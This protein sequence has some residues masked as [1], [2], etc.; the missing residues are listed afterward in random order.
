MR[1]KNLAA[2][3]LIVIMGVGVLGC[4]SEKR[5]LSTTASKEP[6]MAMITE[7]SEDQNITTDTEGEVSQK[8]DISGAHVPRLEITST[9]YD[10]GEDYE[11]FYGSYD[12]AAI[13]SEDYPELKQAVDRWFADF[14][15]TYYSSADRY[16]EDAKE[17]MRSEDYDMGSFYL[18][19]FAKVTR[20]D[21]RITSIV[22]DETGFTGGAHGFSYM[23]GVTFDSKTGKEITFADLGNVKEDVKSYVTNYVEQ[24]RQEG[25]SYDFFEDNIDTALD[26]PVW[27][28]NGL[29]LNVIFNEY[30]IASYAEGRTVVTIPYSEL[31]G[32][33]NDYCLDGE[34]MYVE[35]MQNVSCDIDVDE[36]ETKEKIEL[37]G[38]Y[39]ENGEMELSLK[40]DDLSLE[41]G[42]C[43]RI[44]N[45]YYVKAE[46]GRSFVLVSYDAMSDD[47]V[48]ELIEVSSGTPEK[49][50]VHQFGRLTAISTDD[51]GV[52]CRIN[53]LGSYNAKMSYRFSE[54]SLVPEEER[55][56]FIHAKDWKDRM[57]PVTKATVSVKIEK[58]GELTEQ[59]LPAGTKI[60]P[61]NTDN[62]TVLGFE[63]EDG[64]YGEIQFIRKEGIIYINNVQEYDCFEDLPYTG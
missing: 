43:S 30:V 10:N 4:S 2:V 41:I 11:Y 64:T 27:Y 22:I 6:D 54:G 51:I 13:V 26:E 18:N 24:R 37:S 35:L 62:E 38:E 1:T 40:V 45:A 31:S 29:G 20:S 8:E 57:M 5:E 12:M 46:N 3:M 48:T 49:A 7:D 56:T 47:F 60:Y 42:H 36:D 39:D 52:D 53:T 58:N 32:F 9:Y 14:E 44:T 16:I 34:A 59:E 50:D 33:N 15:S 21:A 28:L 55:F 63:L 17:A 61:V 19:E 25:Y 23:Y